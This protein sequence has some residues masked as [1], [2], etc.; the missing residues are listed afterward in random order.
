MLDDNYHTDSHPFRVSGWLGNMLYKSGVVWFPCWT[1]F[2]ATGCSTDV[3]GIIFR[4]QTP[5]VIHALRKAKHE[6]AD[7]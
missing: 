1:Q 6:L 7:W 2:Q 3:A 5:A 4:T